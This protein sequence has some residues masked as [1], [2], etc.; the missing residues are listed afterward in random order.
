M[1]LF[2]HLCVQSR[3]HGPKFPSD[4]KKY[5]DLKPWSK[6]RGIWSIFQYLT[7]YFQTFK[8]FKSQQSDLEIES[9]IRPGMTPFFL[10]CQWLLKKAK[11][12]QG[13]TFKEGLIQNP[14]KICYRRQEMRLSRYFRENTFLIGWL[15]S[16][17]SQMFLNSTKTEFQDTDI[18]VI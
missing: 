2:Q 10:P 1:V 9:G 18:W 11:Q 14:R 5:W 16:H 6:S 15:F 3:E 12:L 4:S 8:I 17:S 7:L 13:L